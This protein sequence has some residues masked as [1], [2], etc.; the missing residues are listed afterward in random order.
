M[1]SSISIPRSERRGNRDSRQHEKNQTRVDLHAVF[2]PGERVFAL[3]I[4][5]NFCLSNH[6]TQNIDPLRS[7]IQK[8]F[9]TKLRNSPRRKQHLK[10]LM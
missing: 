3:H 6:P 9:A 2:T 10:F 7:T 4:M 8:H 5:G 1:P